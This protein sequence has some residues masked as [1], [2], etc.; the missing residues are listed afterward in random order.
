[1]TDVD[2]VWKAKR[3]VST[4]KARRRQKATRDYNQFVKERMAEKPACVRCKAR[5][6]LLHHRR[7][8]SQGGAL[9]S[10][11]NTVPLCNSCHL[12]THSNPAEARLVHLL[13]FRGDPDYEMLGA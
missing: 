10:R 3:R 5:A 6:V 1:M 2:P 12:W 13:V 4:P 9:V 7:R 11:V 8:R